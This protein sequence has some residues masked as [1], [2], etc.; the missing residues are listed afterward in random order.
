MTTPLMTTILA[1]GVIV[2][3]RSLSMTSIISM[4]VALTSRLE[5]TDRCSLVFSS[6]NDGPLFHDLRDVVEAVCSDWRDALGFTIT[7]DRGALEVYAHGPYQNGTTYTIIGLNK[8]GV[9]LLDAIR[10]GNGHGILIDI[11]NIED[12]IGSKYMIPIEITD[13]GRD[14]V[15]QAIQFS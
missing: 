4:E 12:L 3:E 7:L 1:T 6:N 5:K 10:H 15:G 14:L 8:D 13:D 2:G 11:F 9:N